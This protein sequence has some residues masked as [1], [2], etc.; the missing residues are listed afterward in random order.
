MFFWMLI[1]SGKKKIELGRSKCC[2][3]EKQSKIVYK[4]QHKHGKTRIHN[5]Y[6]LRERRGGGVCNIFGE[7]KKALIF[8]RLSEPSIP[9]ATNIQ[10]RF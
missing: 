3:D 5:S 4:F 7:R 2:P 6:F 10:L 1:G 9:S 8:P